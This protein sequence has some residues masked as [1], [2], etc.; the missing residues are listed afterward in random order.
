MRLCI[1]IVLFA[2]MLNAQTPAPASP[3]GSAPA[4]D[5]ENGKKLYVNRGCF[6]CHNVI[7][8]GNGGAT[9]AN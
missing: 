8:Q 6:Q 4:G 5:A 3:A 1:L 9:P 7:A 2:S